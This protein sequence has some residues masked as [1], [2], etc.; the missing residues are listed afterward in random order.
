MMKRSNDYRDLIKQINEVEKI[1]CKAKEAG[2]FI[3]LF[4]E[5]PNHVRTL[6]DFLDKKEKEY[7][8]IPGRTEKPIKVV[9]KGLPIDMDLEEIKNDLVS[10]KFRVDK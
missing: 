10:K 6:T 8:V 2:E 4:C 1:P 9:I 3:K 7:F 5:T